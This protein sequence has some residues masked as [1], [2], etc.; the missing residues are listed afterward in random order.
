[1]NLFG[2]PLGPVSI[3]INSYCGQGIKYSDLPDLGQCPSLNQSQDWIGATPEPIT[4]GSSLDW[5]A[6]GHMARPGS[7]C[8]VNPLAPCGL[9]VTEGKADL[10]KGQL[11]YYLPVRRM[12]HK[13]YV[14]GMCGKKILERS[15]TCWGQ[16]FQKSQSDRQPGASTFSKERKFLPFL[17]EHVTPASLPDLV[18]SSQQRGPHLRTPLEV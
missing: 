13:P 2:L 7:R 8:G 15:L 9:C 12:R 14:K 1:M 16:E 11:E 4:M 3:S 5:S 10:S 17:L 6:L 18:L